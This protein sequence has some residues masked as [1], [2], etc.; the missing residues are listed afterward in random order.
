MRH[1]FLLLVLAAALILPSA[2]EDTA[3]PRFNVTPDAEGFVRLDTLTG[4]I[5]QCRKI[6]GNWVC[7][8]AIEAEAASAAELR[9]LGD[10]VEA[11]DRRLAVLESV[12]KKRLEPVLQKSAGASFPERL[13]AKLVTLASA[14]R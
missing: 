7:E 5:A 13:M 10:R 2:A 14:L 12:E 4:A 3:R 1:A 8:P 9:R 6:D 11:I